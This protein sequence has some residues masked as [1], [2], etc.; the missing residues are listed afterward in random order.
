M[1]TFL[2]VSLAQF[3]YEKNTGKRERKKNNYLVEKA[4]L[5]KFSENCLKLLKSLRMK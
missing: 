3:W 1:V 2:A 5:A 4:L